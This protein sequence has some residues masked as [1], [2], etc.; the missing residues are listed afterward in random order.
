MSMLPAIRKAFDV[1]A[2]GAYAMQNHHN[3]N[4]RDITYENTTSRYPVP[5]R[6][7]C[8]LRGGLLQSR[9]LGFEG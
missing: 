7:R 2:R 4:G 6:G 8:Y 3:L 1:A 5:R 9:R